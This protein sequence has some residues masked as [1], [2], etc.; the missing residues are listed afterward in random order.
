MASLNDWV[1]TLGA[2]RVHQRVDDIAQLLQVC[3][4]KVVFEVI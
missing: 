2:S 4:V 3:V 1:K